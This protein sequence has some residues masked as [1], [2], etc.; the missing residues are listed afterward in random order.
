MGAFLSAGNLSPNSF[1]CFSVWNIRLS[2]A[3]ILSAFSLIFLS[4]SSCTLASS[5]IRFISSSLSPDEASIL[6]LC[7]LF[8]PLSFAET[9][10]IP[11]ASISKVTSIWGTPLGAGGI[12]S[13][14]NLPMVLLPEAT[15]RSPCS[16]CISTEG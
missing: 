13:R 16:T 11:L 12:P 5:R 14:W 7:C 1:S 10:R 3:F 2:A 9:L 15:G 6:I 4:S 8:V